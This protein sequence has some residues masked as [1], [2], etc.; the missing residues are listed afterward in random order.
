MQQLLP[1]TEQNTAQHML[2]PRVLVIDNYDSF[3][4]NLV[5]AL[6]ELG[7]GCDVYRND[8]ASVAELLQRECHGVLLSPGPGRP[9]QAGILLE[10]LERA[11]QR[12]PILGV[13]L[14]HQAIAQAF[15]AQVTRAAR[16]LHGKTCPIEHDGTGLFAGLPPKVQQARYNSLSVDPATLPDCLAPTAWSQGEVMALTHRERPLHGVQFHP[17][18]HLSERGSQLLHNW[19]QSLHPSDP[20]PS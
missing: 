6:C 19:L 1:R 7:A 15:G 18:S 9:E 14:G 17:E 8:E 12:L 16:A 11:P 4:F 10:L 20:S 5:H 3:T 13:C 2:V